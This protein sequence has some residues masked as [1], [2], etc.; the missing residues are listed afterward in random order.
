M[1]ADDTRGMATLDF[2]ASREGR[3]DVTGALWLPANFADDALPLVVFGHGGSGDRYQ[4]PIPQ[5]AQRFVN[6]L[7][8]PAL[9]MDGPVHGLRR[10][11]PG[12]RVAFNKERQSP[13]ATADFL[14]EWHFVID[15]AFSHE[16]IGPRPVAY[17]G[18]SMGSAFGIPMIAER[19]DVMV[20]TIGLLGTSG[21]FDDLRPL[22]LASAAKITHPVLYLMQ[23]E[24]E[25]FGRHGY[26]EL[27]DALASDDKR[28]HANPGL[29]PH[30]P[31]EE[32]LFAFEFMKNHIEGTA[33]KGTMAPIAD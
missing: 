14:E 8:C 27:F 22:L 20:S 19:D 21:P 12:G 28:L 10:V 16:S 3:R 5:L 25:L 6:E 1:K 33:P 24:D 17:F 4:N 9:A 31:Q 32:I 29:H 11:E 30:V 13:T 18:L 2:V 23:L 15:L 7:G 26:L